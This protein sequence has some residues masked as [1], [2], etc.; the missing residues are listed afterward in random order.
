MCGHH[1]DFHGR[2]MGY[3]HDGC[4]CHGGHHGNADCH[5]HGAHFSGHGWAFLTHEERI[6]RLVHAKEDLET[7]LAEI[8]KTLSL[9]QPPDKTPDLPEIPK[10]S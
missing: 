4:G 8:Q 10:E 9:L 5:G 2:G 3:G 1:G 7:Q 6:R